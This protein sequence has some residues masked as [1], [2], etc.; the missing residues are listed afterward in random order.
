MSSNSKYRLLIVDDNPAIHTDFC[1]ILSFEDDSE[2]Q[3]AEEELFG[4]CSES[5]P[6]PMPFEFVIDSAFQGEEALQKVVEA[7][8]A[9]QPYSLAFV[10][11]RMPPGWNGLK[12]IQELWKVAP[13]LQVVICTAYTD[14]TWQEICAQLG[15]SDNLL[16]LKKPFDEME[17]L[18]LAVALT[19]K[20]AVTRKADL[21]QRDLEQLVEKRTAELRHAAA[22]DPL[23]DLANRTKFNK[24]LLSAVEQAESQ[25][26]LAAVH[27]IDL[28]EFKSI[29]DTLGHMVGDQLLVSVSQRLQSTVRRE[30]L[31]CRFGGD[32]FAI[33]QEP[34]ANMNEVDALARRVQE[35]FCEPIQ[36]EN[37]SVIVDLS[38]GIAI[39]PT[40]GTA[41]VD[42][43]KNADLALYRAKGEGR[44]CYRFFKAEMD[45]KIQSERQ[46]AVRLKKAV[47]QEQF[48]LHYQPLFQAKSC[49]VC[50]FEA[51]V[52]WRDPGRGLVSPSNFIS[53]A[54]ESGLI[55]PLGEWIISQACEQAAKWPTSMR[56]AVNVSAIQF[57]SGGLVEAIEKN[58]MSTG[59]SPDRIE[60]EITETVLLRDCEESLNTLH[61]IH[62]MGVRIVLDDFGT[63]YS[64][65]SYLRR[66]PFDKLKLDKSFV[67]DVDSDPDAHA[68]VRAVA[69]LG[70]CLGIETTAEGVETDAQLELVI[71]AGYQ[72]FQGYLYAKPMPVA[73]IEREFFSSGNVPT[74]A[75]VPVNPL[76]EMSNNIDN[77]NY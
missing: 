39:A 45:R 15:H 38:S 1:K 11:M 14:S 71:D 32:E 70:E 12:T 60:I 52:R 41:P 4:A 33:I 36:I 49:T 7:N 59:I 61:E 53:I 2:L 40:D 73:D 57:R 29:N 43:V 74:I 28:D 76:A 22:H 46:L 31:V 50:G 64:S 69:N 3:M 30:D 72:Q 20:W 42:V 23:T 68:I 58:L 37:N 75:T 47:K 77:L 19:K 27:L 54:E 21:R 16:I 44:G 48:V 34:V 66:F 35:V 62:D 5:T 51:L 13:N 18:Q 24:R 55:V 10:D 26:T 6:A 25:G 9:D 8:N 65:L 17:V 67:N 63:G 56:V